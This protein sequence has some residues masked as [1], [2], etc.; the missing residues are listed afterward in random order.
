MPQAPKAGFSTYWTTFGQ[1]PRQ[2]LMIHCALA[3][4][5]AWGGLARHLSGALTMTAFDLPGHGRS[6]EW[7]E[8]GEIQGETARIGFDLMQGSFDI[9]GHSYG[10]TVALRMAVLQPAVV[11]SLVLIE[12]VF[13]AAAYSGLPVLDAERDASLPGFADA[14]SLGD[15]HAAAEIFL[16]EWGGGVQWSEVSASDRDR[17]AQQMSL[18][19]A[20]GPALHED[21]GGM[22]APG[23]LESLSL[24]VLLIEGSQSPAVIANINEALSARIPNTQRAIIAGASHMAPITH[25]RQVS[26]EILRFL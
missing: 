14:I 24:P 12:P 23:V 2:A 15:N 10:A 17:L 19:V 5:G 7:D 6:Q 13:F 26:A 1:G 3:T 25:S 8:R 18:I 20:S 11:R 21:V 22:L 4:S 9:I 16:S